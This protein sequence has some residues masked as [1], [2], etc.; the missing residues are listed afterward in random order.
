MMMDFLAGRKQAPTLK[1]AADR[2]RDAVNKVLAEGTH[3]T[4]DLGGSAGTK[5]MTTAILENI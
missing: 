1:I 3:V 2:I 4:R 5:E